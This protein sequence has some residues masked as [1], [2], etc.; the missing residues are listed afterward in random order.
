MTGVFRDGSMVWALALAIVVPALIIAAGEIDERL[1][2]R[3][4]GLRPVV[5][6]LRWWALPL[7]AV[8]VVATA[9]FAVPR[10]SVLVRLTAT[11]VLLSAAAAGLVAVRVAVTRYRRRRGVGTRGGVPQ[12]PGHRDRLC[13]RPN[14]AAMRSHLSRTGS[15]ATNPLHHS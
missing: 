4:S 3:D 6:V 12:L 5:S 14:P 7:S 2:Q 13:D 1:R 9:V 15:A 10:D 11:G 8:W